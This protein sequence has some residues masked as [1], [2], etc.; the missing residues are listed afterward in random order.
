M[1]RLILPRRAFLKAGAAALITLP[2]IIR[3]ASAQLGGGLMFPG[4]G[5]AHSAGGDAAAT[6]AFLVRADAIS[7]VGATERA[8]Y[9]NLINGLVAAGVLSKLDALWLFAT[10]TSAHSLLNLVQNAYNC[11]LIT[12]PTFTA[13]RGWAPG[14]GGSLD[15]NFNP[16]TATAPNYT[17][18][19]LTIAPLV[20]LSPA[21]QPA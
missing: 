19:G 15:T 17:Q 3:K 9:K 21:P 13:D 16:T 14:S 20:A 10:D 11:T 1:S 2:A 5:T 8:A 7:T 4:P 18:N 6:T 12:S